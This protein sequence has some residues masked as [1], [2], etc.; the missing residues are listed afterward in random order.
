M[1]GLIR[2]AREQALANPRVDMPGAEIIAGAPRMFVPPP[3]PDP[4]PTLEANEREGAVELTWERSA[5]TIGLSVEIHR[6]AQENFMPNSDTLIAESSFSRFTDV[7]VPEGRSHYAVVFVSGKQRTTPMRAS[8]TVRIVREPVVAVAT[9]TIHGNA[10]WKN[11]V[12][13]CT[14]GGHVTVAHRREFDLAQPLSVE[15]WVRFDKPSQMP[16]VVSCGLWKQ[17]GW[18]I[19]WLGGHWRWHV[20]G[21]DCDGGKPVVGQWMHLAGISDG[22]TLRLFQDGKLIAERTAAVAKT[23]WP[24][25]LHVG[26]Y[27]GSPGAEFQVTGQITGV[28]IYT[29]SLAETEIAAAAQT[30]PQ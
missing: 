20:G 16:V 22:Q 4:L 7:A 11:G 2:Q 23:K 10:A 15:C 8:A 25:P 12:L 28:K 21:V 5:R 30:K 1:L 3:L 27:S 26:Q 14:G 29:R 19:Q 9:G 18:F 17:A 24:G 6:S 13:D